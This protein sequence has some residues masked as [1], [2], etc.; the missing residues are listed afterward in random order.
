MRARDNPFRSERVEAIRYRFADAGWD[1]LMRRLADLEYRAAIVGPDGSGKT[2]LLEEL[3]PRLEGLG[4]AVRRLFL[5]D[6][7]RPDA[8]SL[9]L[10]CAEPGEKDC[11]LFDGADLVGRFA[12]A[13]F[14]RQSR[15]AAGLIITSHRPGLLPTLIECRTTPELLDDIVVHILGRGAA[16]LGDTPRRLFEKHDGNLRDAL[17]GLYDMYAHVVQDG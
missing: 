14:K 2:T 4:F 11:I 3:A 16:A 7:K 9:K 1:G 15:L 12:W 13:R 10:S 6:Q 17:R 5:N 8:Q